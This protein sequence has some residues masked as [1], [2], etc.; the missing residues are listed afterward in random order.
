MKSTNTQMHDAMKHISPNPVSNITDAS[1][2]ECANAAD[3]GNEN[4]PN[5]NIIKIASPLLVLPA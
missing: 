1:A 5:R 3:I 2:P 4:S